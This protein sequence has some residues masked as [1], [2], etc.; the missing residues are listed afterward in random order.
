MP[1]DTYDN[2]KLEIISFSHRGDVDL[3]VDTFIDM[4]E[5]EMFANDEA[6]L[7][8]RGQELTYSTT[9]TGKT[10]ALPSD[11][12]AMRSIRLVTD[13]TPRELAF[14]APAQMQSQTGTGEPQ[15]FTVTS[16]IEFDITPDS[17]YDL[18]IIYF[19][20]PEPLSD[21][22]QTNAVLDT[23]ANI[24][25]FGAL[26][27]LN[28]YADEDL[29]SQKYYQRFIRAIKGANKRDKQGRFGP[30]PAMTVQ[31]WTP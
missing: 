8:T 12:Q 26:W 3:K 1:L 31:G 11:F 6:V 27:A 5:Q 28:E 30:A 25:L 2:L 29:K 16:Q 23:S 13:N 19:A 15:R 9:T 22:V 7:Q 24:Y 10:L 17:A 21:T 4:A 18:E 20:I 14:R